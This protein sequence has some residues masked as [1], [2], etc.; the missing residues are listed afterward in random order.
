MSN[1]ELKEVIIE[2]SMEYHKE[3]REWII[4]KCIETDTGINFFGVF[5]GTRNECIDELERIKENERKCKNND[6]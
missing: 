5:H 6:K 1:G 2:Y 3:R 4:W